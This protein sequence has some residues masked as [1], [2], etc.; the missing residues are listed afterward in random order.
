MKTE[1][2]ETNGAQLRVSVQG[3]GETVLFLHGGY[4]NL[5]VWDEHVDRVAEKYQVL[6]FD[7]RGYG[8]SSQPAGPFSYYEDIKGVLDYYRVEKALIVASSFGG[9]AALDFAL[10]YPQFVDKLILVGPSINGMNYPFRMKWEGIMD[11][12]RVNR[13]GI[14]KAA[15]VFLR[16]KFWSY[17]V[18]QEE[19][20]KLRFRE[21]YASNSSFYGSKPSWARPLT[22]LAVHRL[23]EIRTPVLIIEPENDHPFNRK[24]C[25]MLHSRLSNADRVVMKNSGHYP[26]LEHPSEFTDLVLNFL[27]R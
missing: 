9:S 12:L 1:F 5:S 18:P 27:N 24:A 17:I 20:R 11:Y 26:H 7:Q 21:L 22:P 8:Q 19:E 10:E 4:S 14:E 16:K 25:G 6:R 23:E 13:V 3:Q 15:D 2:I